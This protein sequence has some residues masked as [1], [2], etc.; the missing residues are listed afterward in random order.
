MKYRCKIK[1]IYRFKIELGSKLLE[2]CYKYDY[3]PYNINVSPT[4][5]CLQQECYKVGNISSIRNI[6]N[7]GLKPDIIC[8][9]NACTNKTNISVVK[10]LV[11]QG[12]KPD[13]YCLKNSINYFSQNQT[14]EY[15]NEILIEEYEKKK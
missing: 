14:I 2:N 1:D 5:A 10:Y 6:V 7:K 15:V 9:R 4:L 11:S 8:L 12:I 3:F 13:L